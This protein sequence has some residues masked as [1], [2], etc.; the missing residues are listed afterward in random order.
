MASPS[1]S[2]PQSLAAGYRRLG[3][4]LL[5]GEG[6]RGL[7][8]RLSG[9]LTRP[10]AVVDLRGN[11]LAMAPNRMQWPIDALRGWQPD[12]ETPHLDD[13]HVL[14]IT[15]GE[16]A[17]ALLCVQGPDVDIELPKFTA[18]LIAA[19]IARRQAE[20]AGR[21]ELL[22]QVLDD[23][24]RGLLPDREATRRLVQVGLDPSRPQRVVVG[25]ANTPQHRLRSF[26][27]NLQTLLA[28]LDEPFARA[29]IGSR[30][31]M[32]VSDGPA[33][34]TVAQNVLTHLSNIGTQTRVGVG[35]AYDGISGLRL[36]YLEAVDALQQGPGIHE[37]STLDLGRL[38]V[39]ADL[40]LPLRELAERLLRPLLDHDARHS[41]Q[42]VAT[43]R[44]W[45]EGDC[46]P[47]PVVE[48]MFVHRNTVRYR[49]TLIEKLTGADLS[50][51]SCRMHFWFAL[52]CFDQ[53]AEPAAPAEQVP[54]T[55]TVTR[56]AASE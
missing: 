46:L 44:T 12:V 54:G 29:V 56:A 36:S 10:V 2:S 31:V 48:Q 11:L 51:F 33:V 22:G 30:V 37:S 18:G 27:W 4:A 5:H 6:V 21:R 25:E 55:T 9:A 50:S 28:G 3:D 1:V 52:R 53:P 38:L 19:D 15:L 20:V 45:L 34:T 49:L 8:N 42:L 17:V 16:E 26:P 43:L 24:V 40:G 39:V 23:I 7:V 32:V 14:P 13:I 35:G 41:T 47:R